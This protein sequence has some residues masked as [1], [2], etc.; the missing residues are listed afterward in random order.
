M[1]AK[2]S[3]KDVLELLDIVGRISSTKKKIE[4]IV[5]N[6]DMPYLKK[7]VFYA[8]DFRKRYHTTSIDYDPDPKDLTQQ[9]TVDGIFNY[10]DYLS[11]KSGCTDKECS[12]LGQLSSLDKE[13]VQVVNLILK[14]DLRCGAGKKMF[15][16]VWPDLPYFEIQTCVSDLPKFLKTAHDNVWASLKKDGVRTWNMVF[17]DGSVEHIS[18]RGLEYPNFGIFDDQLREVAAVLHE[19]W[20]LSYPIILDGEATSKDKSFNKLMTSIRKMSNIDPSIFLLN[21]FDIAI[22][23]IPFAIR[24][25]MLEDAFEK[26]CFP[27]MFLLEHWKVNYE[28]PYQFRGLLNWATEVMGEEGLV[29][30][31]E[32]SPYEFKEKSRYWCKYKPVETYDLDVVGSFGG[33]KGTKYETVL[34]G[35]ICLY[36]DAKVR[37]GSGFS[38]EERIE[39]MTHRP[40]KIEVACK[41]ITPAGSLRE[42]RFI[43]IRD[44]K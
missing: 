42:P 1:D 30:K 9:R 34:G 41:G 7:V 13:T 33:K 27:N 14:K 4:T 21:I 16:K 11:G 29:F 17:E 20:E 8:L 19:D 23:D 10:L 18:R 26:K 31:L 40:D 43:R 24:F 15:Q 32:K 44:D 2:N 3:L 36:G 5:S 38:D 39:F 6:K 22:K 35:L 25:H 28:H 12:K 37:V